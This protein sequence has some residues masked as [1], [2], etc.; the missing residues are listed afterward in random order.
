MINTTG[1]GFNE[2]NTLVRSSALSRSVQ[3][4]ISFLAGIFSGLDNT[5]ATAYLPTGQQV[6][7]L[8][9]VRRK[10]MLSNFRRQSG[11]SSS[12]MASSPRT[13]PN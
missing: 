9:L 12:V 11:P 4:A 8:W 10:R 7:A 3:S 1:V 13:R 5:T 2:Y 6:G